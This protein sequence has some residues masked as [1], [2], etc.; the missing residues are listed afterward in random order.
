MQ[1]ATSFNSTSSDV[2][3]SATDSNYSGVSWSAVIAGA[4]AAAVLSL[5]LF[6][7]GFGLGLSSLSPWHNEG[8]EASTFGWISVAW[9]AFTQIAASGLGGYLA[10]RLRVKWTQV[11]TDEVYFRDT[12]H[13]FLAWTIASLVTA[14]VLSSATTAVANGGMKAGAAAATASA[15]IATPIAAGVGSVGAGS[16]GGS[17]ESTTVDYYVDNL[18]HAMAA[19]SE[20]GA[21][22]AA[23]PALDAS[24]RAEVARIFTY[25]L[26]KGELSAEDKSYLGQM[27]ARRTGMTAGN[28]ET[29]VNAVYNQAR[30][31]IEQA[32]TKAQQLADKARKAAAYTALWMFIALLCGAFVASIAATWG[33]RQRD[34]VRN[35]LM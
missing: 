16:E 15:A 29:R 12:A 25:S 27:L 3:N 20:P 8:I 34:S 19:S 5:L 35:V 31:S 30:D 23:Q 13:G 32:K 7:L 17:S 10:G 22:P 21:Q 2:L 26:S 6:I 1:S 18:F 33:G 14:A 24:D 4:A 28:A 9:V 11:H